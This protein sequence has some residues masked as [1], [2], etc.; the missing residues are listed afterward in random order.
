MVKFPGASVA[1]NTPVGSA[2]QPGDSAGLKKEMHET[3]KG[4]I[5]RRLAKKN[6]DTGKK[7]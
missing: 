4:A 6:T 7:N 3:R 5:K 2:G 1:N